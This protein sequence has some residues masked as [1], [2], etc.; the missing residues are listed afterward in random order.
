MRHVIQIFLLELV[1]TCRYLLKLC[2]EIQ[3]MFLKLCRECGKRIC[4]SRGGSGRKWWNNKRGWNRSTLS[5]MHPIK[6]STIDVNSGCNSFFAREVKF[7]ELRRW[8]ISIPKERFLFGIN[9]CSES[10]KSTMSL[11]MLTL[12][13]FKRQYQ[14]W[15]N[16]PCV[17]IFSWF[18]Q[19]VI[20]HDLRKDL[21]SESVILHFFVPYETQVVI[22]VEQ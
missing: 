18:Y 19:E 12:M 1:L 14:K 4:R 21:S 13:S 9:R 2:V 17:A 22:T 16:P 20:E 5:Y 10:M 6:K 7:K 15:S 3:I 8:V 11:R